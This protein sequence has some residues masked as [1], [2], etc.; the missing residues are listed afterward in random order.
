[1]REAPEW[2]TEEIG[3]IGG[4]NPYGDPVFRLLWSP[5]AR[6]V[7]GG[8]WQ[9]DGFTGYRLAP[10]VPGTACWALMVWEPRELQ[11]SPDRWEDAYRD[12]ETGL[13]QCGGYPKYGRYALLQRFLH[14]EIVR[15]QKERRWVD[16]KGQMRVEVLQRQEFVT[17]RMEPCG[18]ILDL[19]LPCLVKWKR[20]SAE[21]KAA[22]ILEEERR[23]REKE[24]K[25]VKEAWDGNRMS[26][27]MRGS[28]LVQKRAELIDRGFKAAMAMAAQTGLGMRIAQ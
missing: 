24:A 7:F 20:L 22:A 17:W 5:E 13:L 11:G 8:R 19:I 10:A 18:L 4:T 6:T 2:F 21:R 25:L 23:Q 15:Q 16:G 9:H 14:R 28:E 1:M 27:A 12:E 3:R 26:R